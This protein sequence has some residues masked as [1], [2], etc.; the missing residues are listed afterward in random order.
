[1][2]SAWVYLI[3]F[4]EPLITGRRSCQHYLGST[5]SFDRRM[6]D[7]RAGRGARLLQLVNAAGIAWSV[8]R[9][10]ETTSDKRYALERE[11]KRQRNHKKLCPTCNEGGTR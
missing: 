3:H 5:V 2:R 4:T 7:H 11:L 8:V 9:T 1:M 10:W 6:A